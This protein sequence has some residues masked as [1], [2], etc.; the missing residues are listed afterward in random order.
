MRRDSP[1][2]CRDGPRIIF[3]CRPRQR[4][5]V[6]KLRGMVRDIQRRQAMLTLARLSSVLSS[7]RSCRGADTC[8]TGTNP[9]R[10][11]PARWRGWR[12]P[13]GSVCGIVTSRPFRF[14]FGWLVGSGPRSAGPPG[15]PCMF[16][17]L[18]DCY[19]CVWSVCVSGRVRYVRSVC[20]CRISTSRA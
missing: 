2:V 14:S 20:E 6:R 5:S 17:L 15:S 8:R 11:R 19:I 4:G 16:E 9:A 3:R 12:R 10:G 7:R 18:I 13:R 1:S